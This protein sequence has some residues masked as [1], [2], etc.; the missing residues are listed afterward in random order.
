M[1]RFAPLALGLLFCA[2]TTAEPTAPPQLLMARGGYPRATAAHGDIFYLSTGRTITTWQ[3]GQDSLDA[4]GDTR[5]APLPGSIMALERHGDYLY[6]AFWL[7]PR[8]RIAVYSLADRARPVLL[9]TATYGSG[10]SAS[11]NAMR[12]IGQYLYV[13]DRYHGIFAADLAQPKHLQFQQISTVSAIYDEV[14]A[15]GSRVYVSGI[16]DVGDGAFGAFDFS[17]PQSPQWLGGVGFP[18]CDWMNFSVSG[19]Y[20]FSFGQTLGVFDVTNPAAPQLLTGD[21]PLSPGSPLL[22]GN[23]AWNVSDD[24][25]QVLDLSNPLQPAPA[26]TLPLA[27]APAYAAVAQRAGEHVVL[28]YERGDL[29]RLD[30]TQ[31]ATPTLTGTAQLP[32]VPGGPAGAVRGEHLIVANFSYFSV[33]D[34]RSL[35]RLSRQTVALNGQDNGARDITIEGDRAYLFRGDT[36]GVAAIASDDSLTPLGF[37]STAQITAATVSNGTLY[38]THFVNGAHKL[39]IVDLRE[40]ATPVQIADVPTPGVRSLA[41]RG[42]RLYTVAE[43]GLGQRE[44]RIL[45]ISTPQS[46]QLLGSLPTCYGNLQL[47]SRRQLAAVECLGYVQIMDVSNPAQPQERS[48]IAAQYLFS[49]LMHG[50]SI[51]VATASQLQEWDLADPSQPQLL[52]ERTVAHARPHISDDAHLYLLT[53]GVHV[54]KLDRLFADGLER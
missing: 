49:T 19:N 9:D 51:Y 27:G 53:D 11:L 4:V 35:E 32:A 13:F 12:I 5:T 15:V 31:P 25:I 52:H 38:A 43:V 29:K 2:T 21:A 17:A 3:Q 16:D 46:P 26:G 22:L 40:P 36:V 42:N 50:N 14:A 1:N 28:A 24:H 37:W 10:T 18:C 41:A 7:E 33:L 44:L 54:L 47:D 6:A 30:A 48:R 39:A 23:Y 20:A 8:P 45:D 34:R